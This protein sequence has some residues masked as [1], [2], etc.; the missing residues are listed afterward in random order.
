MNL[1]TTLS[2]TATTERNSPMSVTEME[3]ETDTDVPEAALPLTVDLHALVAEVNATTD[4]AVTA[5]TELEAERTAVRTWYREFIQDSWEYADR[6]QH[7]PTWERCCA[8]AGVPGRT[9]S[10]SVTVNGTTRVPITEDTLAASAKLP[11]AMTRIMVAALP[12]E[13]RFTNHDAAW[14]LTLPAMSMFPDDWDPL[15]RRGMRGCVC[16]AA[17]EAY[18]VHARN[19]YGSTVVVT[20]MTVLSGCSATHHTQEENH[21]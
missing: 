2:P 10:R 14:H 9:K 7:C 17:R 15:D 13:D 19:I 21:E 5:Q 6:A 11:R 16:P 8:E 12:E 3:V 18:R 4:R 20:D 1:V